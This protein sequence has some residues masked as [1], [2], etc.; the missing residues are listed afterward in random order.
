MIWHW[1][2]HAAGVS[3]DKGGG[4]RGRER[5]STRDLEPRGAIQSSLRVPRWGVGPWP[6]DRSKSER[7]VRCE[8]HHELH[9]WTDWTLACRRDVW[10]AAVWG[11]R[12][13]ATACRVPGVHVCQS[14]GVRAGTARR[15]MKC[16][17]NNGLWEIRRAAWICR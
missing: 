2:W 11:E 6:Q 9:R 16:I 4:G 17:M 7:A 13:L 15:R 12:I 14:V 3:R 10:Q 1:H 5:P 8:H